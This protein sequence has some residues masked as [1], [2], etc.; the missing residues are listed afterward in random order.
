MNIDPKSATGK[1]VVR[2]LLAIPIPIGSQEH[3][4]AIRLLTTM[5][6]E[7]DKSTDGEKHE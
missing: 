7:S 1:L 2:A 5:K 3:E 6:E 4:L